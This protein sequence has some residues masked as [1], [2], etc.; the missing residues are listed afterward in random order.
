MGKPRTALR[1]L[2]E[3]AAM[4]GPGCAEHLSVTHLNMCAILSLLRKCVPRPCAC[5]LLS[6]DLRYA[7]QP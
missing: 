5:T 1:V 7:A 3:A 4:E 2:R 6:S